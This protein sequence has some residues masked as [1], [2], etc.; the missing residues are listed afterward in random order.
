[1][2]IVYI[3]KSFKNKRYYTGHTDNLPKRFKK[4][5][6]GWVRSTRN[7]RPWKIIH[8]E[9]YP[10]RSKAC[11]RELKIKSYKGGVKFKKLIGK[12]KGG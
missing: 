1:M 8:T 2:Y 12:R 11:K 9:N 4:H 6:K 7:N 10:T 3:L 5:N